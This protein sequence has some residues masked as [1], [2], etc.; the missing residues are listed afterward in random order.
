ML[1]SWEEV[2]LE[3]DADSVILQRI[4]FLGPGMVSLGP[5]SRESFDEIQPNPF[6]EGCALFQ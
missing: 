5:A 4:C 3:C 1:G 2:F 6:V